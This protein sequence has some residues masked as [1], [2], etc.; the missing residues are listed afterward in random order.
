MLENRVVAPNN[1]PLAGKN[2]G[3]AQNIAINIANEIKGNLFSLHVVEKYGTEYRQVTERAVRE[4]DS[5]A[6]PQLEAIPDT[7]AYDTVFIVFPSWGGT[8][9]M[10]M[11]T[12]L[13]NSNLEGKTIIPVCTHGGSRL[14]RSVN[15]LHSIL[16]NSNII[17]DGLDILGSQA[18]SENISNV[19]KNY[20]NQVAL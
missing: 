7:S 12:F 8:F 19:I 17:D 16:R 6:R 9:P 1:D 13:E 10:A 18:H 11:A 15:D 3:N 2:T 14:G 20:L 5:A 4:R